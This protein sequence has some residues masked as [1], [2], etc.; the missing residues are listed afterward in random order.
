MLFLR[1]FPIRL[2][3]NNEVCS[4]CRN[5][6]DS[7]ASQIFWRMWLK[8]PIQTLLSVAP[9][10]SVFWRATQFQQNDHTPGQLL[11][12]E[13][14]FEFVI[15]KND[16]FT[17]RRHSSRMR[18]VRCSSHLG[19]GV[20]AQE[21]VSTRDCLPR[22]GVC[23]GVVSDR[24]GCLSGGVCPWGCLPRGCLPHIPREQNHRRL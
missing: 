16:S 15:N 9:T 24:R 17:T 1:K 12:V 21:G 19:G 22:V 13:V 10:R 5:L 8:L 20:S 7:V 14:F 2:L 6:Q 11:S 4:F 18:T 23:P 3:L